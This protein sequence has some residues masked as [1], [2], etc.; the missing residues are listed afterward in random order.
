ME[1][2]NSPAFVDLSLVRQA[3]I[4][5]DRQLSVRLLPVV[6]ATEESCMEIGEYK[7]GNLA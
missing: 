7:I 3:D 5:M 6:S 1:K 2:R 4:K